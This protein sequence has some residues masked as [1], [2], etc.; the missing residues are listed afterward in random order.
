M[1]NLF[2]TP[3]T[4]LLLSC[5]LIVGCD[6]PAKKVE[7]AKENVADAKAELAEAN[8][9]YLEDLRKF[10]VEK[11]LRFSENDKII[12]DYRVK[13]VNVKNETQVASNKIMTE[14]EKKNSEMKKKLDDYKSDNIDTWQ[15]FKQNFNRDMDALNKELKELTERIANK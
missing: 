9:E 3:T 12:S 4:L 13:T 7:I 14:L 11:A 2:L 15:L 8:R 5:L 10:R 1:K 6:S